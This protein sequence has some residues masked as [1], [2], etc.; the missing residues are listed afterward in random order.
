M[1]SYQN[2]TATKGAYTPVSNGNGL[3]GGASGKSM[4]KWIISGIL[5][6]VVGIV[7]IVTLHKSPGAS[8]Q[9]AMA[10]A[11]LPINQDGSLMLFDDLSEYY[12]VLNQNKFLPSKHFD[13][14]GVRHV[15]M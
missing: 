5:V 12:F 3:S 2:D 6:V 8:T 4:K 1:T 9:A 11:D 15:R 14:T 13:Y 10:H 7:L